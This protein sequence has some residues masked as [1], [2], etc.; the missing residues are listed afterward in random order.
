[1]VSYIILGLGM[2]A[3][4]ACYATVLVPGGS[5]DMEFELAVLE[6]DE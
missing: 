3:T 1:M 5:N 2:M 4:G 6:G